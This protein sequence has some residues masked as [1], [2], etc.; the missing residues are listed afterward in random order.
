[1]RYA[2]FSDI[3]SNLEALEV[4][5][6]E[7]E[8]RNIDKYYCL[9]DIVGYAANPK[10]CIQIIQDR[11]IDTIAGNHDWAVSARFGVNYFNEYAKAAVLWTQNKISDAEKEFL[12]KLELVRNEVDFVLVHGTLIEPEKFHYMLNGY[13]VSKTFELMGC[14]LCFVG[15]T[16]RAEAF[17]KKDDK[18]SNSTKARVKIQEDTQYIINVGS[19]GQ[20]R[21]NNPKACFCIYDSDEKEVEFLRIE[22]D[23]ASA[24]SKIINGGLPIFLAQRL[25]TGI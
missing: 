18:I 2:I 15:H 19:V 10:E 6:S 11:K 4:V 3:H 20:P 1:M 12:D 9:G 7:Y 13:V 14:E 16:H 23:R 17:I 24:Q 21:D 5:L 25:S 22:Y 8:K